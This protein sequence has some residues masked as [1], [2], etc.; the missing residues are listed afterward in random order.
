M[1]GG[2]FWSAPPMLKALASIWGVSIIDKVN[3]KDEAN[4]EIWTDI[5]SKDAR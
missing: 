4:T 2:P 5:K 3:L 1:G